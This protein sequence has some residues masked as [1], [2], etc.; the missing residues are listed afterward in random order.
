[1]KKLT[2]SL[3]A[4]AF[5]LCFFSAQAVFAQADPCETDADCIDEF[6][7]NGI[8]ACVQSAP[9]E[10]SVCV[11][12]SAPCEATSTTPYCDEEN[13]ICV[14]CLSDDNCTE[15]EICEEGICVEVECETDEDC[16]D[17]DPCTGNET[18][19]DGSCVDG[20]PPCGAL[21]CLPFDNPDG[22]ICVEC[23]NDTDCDD[24]LFCTGYDFC[25]NGTCYSMGDP[26]TLPNGQPAAFGPICDEENDQCVEC[27]TDDNCTDNETPFCVANTCVEC[28]DNEDCSDPLFCNGAEFCDNGT[29]MQGE[30][31]CEGDNETPLC[32][33][34]LD[35]CVECF[36]DRECDNE[37]PRC[38]GVMCVECLDE[39]DCAV[40]EDCVEGWCE[41]QQSDCEI[42]IK[43]QKVRI[44]KKFRPVFR[45]FRVKPAPG[46][47]D[48]YDPYGAIDFGLIQV[49]RA[50]V[51]KK[52]KLKILAYIP[53]GAALDRGEYEVCVGDACGIIILK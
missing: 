24:G 52:G 14:E 38:D 42:I 47:E 7:C 29:C 10:Q 18:C 16:S 2:G 1:M 21:I 30:P 6:F 32:N 20:I 49:Q 23:D 22:Y 35:Q 46:S 31:P 27:L 39:L 28:R 15:G 50:I 4:L 5:L 3:I 26:C 45:K 25:D 17:F 12:G 19:V 13:D 44:K 11:P 9:G 33:E 51:N 34:E 53:A 41:P 43:P 37:T 40:G 8:E 36:T 48:C